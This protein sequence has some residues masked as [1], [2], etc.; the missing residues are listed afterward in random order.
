MQLYLSYP[1]TSMPEGT[2]LQVLRGFDKITLEPGESRLVT[3]GVTRR[4]LS[5]WNTTAQD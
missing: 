5:F 3:F 1:R 2:P 4:D